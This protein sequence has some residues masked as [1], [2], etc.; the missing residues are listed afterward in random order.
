MWDSKDRLSKWILWGLNIKIYNVRLTIGPHGTQIWCETRRI[1]W[2][3]IIKI[4]NVR[5]REIKQLDLM[6]LRINARDSEERQNITSMR[7]THMKAIIINFTTLNIITGNIYIYIVISC[8]LL[9]NINF[10]KCIINIDKLLE[11]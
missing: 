11:S 9:T 2:D 5:L 1:P 4:Y 6:G 8:F 7:T 10:T 3:L